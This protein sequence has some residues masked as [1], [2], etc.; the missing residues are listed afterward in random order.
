MEM[1]KPIKTVHPDGT[2]EWRLNGQFH[3]EDG[4]AVICS[5]GV[6][7]WYL[8]GKMHREGGPAYISTNGF[9]S[10]WLNNRRHRVDGPAII[11]TDGT[12]VWYLNGRQVTPEEVFNQLPKEKK[13]KIM[14]NSLDEWK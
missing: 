1:S 12:R 4:P 2:I 6:Q 13:K 3:R 7:Q 11:R 14:F 8:N 10:W 5:D 9:K